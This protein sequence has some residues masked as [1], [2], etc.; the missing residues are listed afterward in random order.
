[1]IDRSKITEAFKKVISHAILNHEEGGCTCVD[2]AF[3]VIERLVEE[4]S[5][6]AVKEERGR[7]I[8]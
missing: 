2:D 6:K 8:S 3:D 5:M 4:E 7:K 1:M